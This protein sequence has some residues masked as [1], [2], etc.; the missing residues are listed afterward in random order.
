LRGEAVLPKM[1]PAGTRRRADIAGARENEACFLEG[2]AD[3]GHGERPRFRPEAGGGT[4]FCRGPRQK[5]AGVE[6]AA[7]KDK[8]IR[9]ESHAGMPSTHQDARFVAAI[10]DQD[11]ARGVARADAA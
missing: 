3:R 6:F 10:V 9:D 2:L 4:E 5:V 8:G 1:R 11:E 7:R